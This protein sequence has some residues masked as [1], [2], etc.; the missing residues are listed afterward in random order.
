M[1]PTL[2]LLL[3]VFVC[4]CAPS[5][6]VPYDY[7]IEQNN[8]QTYIELDNATIAVDNLEV[9]N[10]YY[11]FGVGI[12]NNSKTRM[13]IDADGILKFANYVSY[14]EDNVQRKLCMVTRMN[15]HIKITYTFW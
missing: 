13:L 3:I 10:D 8:L 6:L 15:D 1:K 7:N 5:R 11:V 4:S 2:T 12:R 14:Q 9:H